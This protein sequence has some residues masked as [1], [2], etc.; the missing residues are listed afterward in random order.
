MKFKLPILFLVALLLITGCGKDA[1]KSD[2]NQVAKEQVSKESEVK[3]AKAMIKKVDTQNFYVVATAASGNNLTYAYY[4]YKDNKVIEKQLYKKDAYFSYK[5]T[6]QGSYKVRVFL[7][8][9]NGKIVTKDTET[10]TM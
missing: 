7:K 3:I 5:I 6:A 10:I 1:S 9:A 8:D 4:V 2:K